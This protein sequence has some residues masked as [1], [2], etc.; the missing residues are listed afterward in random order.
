MLTALSAAGVRLAI[1]DFGTGYSSL[2]YLKQFE[3]NRIKI[4][5]E[6]VTDL[7]VSQSSASI[8]DATIGLAD[9]LGLD[10]IAE[11]IEEAE[12]AR[13]LLELGCEY[14]QGYFMCRP[15][16]AEEIPDQMRAPQLLEL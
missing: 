5:Q 16:P 8:I 3:V 11:G 4:A 14:G 15:A 9:G 6:F 13:I 12:H 1:D 10:V 2:L 7:L